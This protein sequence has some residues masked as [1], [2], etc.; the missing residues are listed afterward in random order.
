MSR[1]LL[2]K[3]VI[4]AVACSETTLAPESKALAR[5]RLA[6]VDFLRQVAEDIEAGRAVVVGRD[7]TFERLR[8]KSPQYD[9]FIGRYDPERHRL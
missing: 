7:E 3:P 1:S 8:V 5:P 6:V 9:I 2:A 4:D